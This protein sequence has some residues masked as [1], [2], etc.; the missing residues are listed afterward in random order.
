MKI[1][2]A[3]YFALPNTGGL[4]TYVNQLKKIVEARGHEVDVL[5]QHPDG[6]HYYLIGQGTR[7][8]KKPAQ[9]AIAEHL[10]SHYDRLLPALDPGILR[11][12]MQRYLFEAAAAAL[13]ISRYDLFHTQDVISTRVLSRIKPPQAPLIATIHGYY[14]FEL[15]QQGVIREPHS[16]HHRFSLAQESI[17]IASADL[18]ILPSK[19]MKDIF[20]RD[21]SVSE[22]GLRVIPNGMDIRTFWAAMGRPTE[23]RKPHGKQVIAVVARLDRLKGH[24]HLLDALAELKA[25]RGGWVCWLIGEGAGRKEIE[26]QIGQ[27]GLQEDVELLGDRSD[28]PAL[29]QLA[30]L[31]VLPSLQENCPYSIMEAQVAGRT[32]IASEVGGIPEMIRP[33]ATGYLTPPADSAALCNS[34]MHALAD[35]AGCERI[36]ATAKAWGSQQWSLE[37][38]RV[39]TMRL[40]QEILQGK[41]VQMRQAQFRSAS[42]QQATSPAWL[43]QLGSSYPADYQLPDPTFVQVM[44]GL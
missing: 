4:W 17:G 39:R 26:M 32:V 20:L 25:R 2:L 21:L 36:G 30:D 12:E 34:I 1:L 19:W 28:V 6:K 10:A 13:D 3:S 27:L 43:A 18:A 14:S 8:E 16:A 29:L 15:L 9:Q 35:R 44:R 11:M 23:Q 33:G 22:K 5:T 38:M 31:C 42:L 41:A 7:F 24:I 40:Y 37:T